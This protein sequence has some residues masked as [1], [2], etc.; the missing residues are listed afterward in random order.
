[1]VVLSMDRDKCL[2]QS[3]DGSGVL[4]RAVV[5]H[6]A[7]RREPT[8]LIRPFRQLEDRLE[9]AD[10]IGDEQARLDRQVGGEDVLRFSK[11]RH[12]LTAGPTATWD[13]PGPPAQDRLSVPA[14]R[15]GGIDLGAPGSLPRSLLP[16]AP[17]GKVLQAPDRDPFVLR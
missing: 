5:R 8:G 14:E 17:A 2:A 12:H 16:V 1:G 13:V 7:G 11:P 4:T 10:R 9:V 15:I 3:L 6:A